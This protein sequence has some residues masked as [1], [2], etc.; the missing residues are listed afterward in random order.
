[1]VT[2]IDKKKFIS[3][4]YEVINLEIKALQ[5]LKNPS[6]AAAERNLPIERFYS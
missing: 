1:M 4:A 6:I 2:L 3:T 5:N